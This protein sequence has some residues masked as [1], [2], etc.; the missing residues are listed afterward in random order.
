TGQEHKTIDVQSGTESLS[1]AFAPDGKTLA[2]AGAWNDSSF[3]PAGGIS[4][5]GV[6]M[7]PKQ[8]YRVLLWDADSGKE[9]RHFDGLGDNV[10]SVAFAP[11][12]QTLAAAGR[13]GRLVVWDA[14]T[15]KERLHILAHPGHRD[16]E[17]SP[18]PCIAFAADGK[19][20][21]SAGTDGTL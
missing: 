20:L 4:I 21:L 8:G 16:D 1:L 11:D 12:G 19:A 17:F 10:N 2:C 7:T 6:M 3:L 5:Q 18:A 9:V 14:A 13:D 15:G